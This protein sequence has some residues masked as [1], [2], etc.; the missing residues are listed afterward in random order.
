MCAPIKININ[1]GFIIITVLCVTG[2]LFGVEYLYNQTGKVLHLTVP[3]PDEAVEEEEIVEE[4]P[5]DEGFVDVSV[6]VEDWT[7]SVSPEELPSAVSASQAASTP[8][9][10][11][12]REPSPHPAEATT[13]SAPADIDVTERL[14]PITS[15]VASTSSVSVIIFSLT[16]K[17]M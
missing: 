5:L 10:A 11:D 6:D 1:V 16:C 13:S 4:L 2:E 8:P 7:V 9:A 15:D 17:F 14:T 12:V 3:E